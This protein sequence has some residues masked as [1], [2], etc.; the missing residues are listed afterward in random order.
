MT[1][2]GFYLQ[3]ALKSAVTVSMGFIALFIGLKMKSAK[4]ALISSFLL[5]ILS[6]ANVGDITLADNAL[7]PALLA[8]VSLIFAVLSVCQ[9]ETKDLM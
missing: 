3:L 7:F 1:S 2:P 5:I 6:Q 4:A 9:A 8:V